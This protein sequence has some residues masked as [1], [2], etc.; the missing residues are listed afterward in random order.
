[1]SAIA[2]RA[3][4]GSGVRGSTTTA[5][6]SAASSS[7]SDGRTPAALMSPPLPNRA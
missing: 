6:A 3:R 4:G 7:T 5:R 1:M 2:Q